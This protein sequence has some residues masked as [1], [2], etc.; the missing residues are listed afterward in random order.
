MGWKSEN[1]AGKSV[2]VEVKSEKVRGKSEK[3]DVKAETDASLSA[4]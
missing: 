3:D 4:N 2:A 1:V